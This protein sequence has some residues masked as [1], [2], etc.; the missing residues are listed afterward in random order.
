MVE[1]GSDPAPATH[2][3]GAPSPWVERFARLVR[4]G[5]VLDLA[6]GAGRHARLFAALGHQ[7]TALDRDAAALAASAGPGI[8]T[9]QYDLEA[10]APPGRSGPGS[11]TASSSPTTCTGRCCPGWPSRCPQPAC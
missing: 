4:A 9:M 3:G 1:N 2:G 5:E 6:C 8:R 10:L 7:V 11:S